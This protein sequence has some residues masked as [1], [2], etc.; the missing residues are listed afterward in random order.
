MKRIVVCMDG[1]W[2]T[3]RQDKPTNIALIARSVSHKETVRAPDGAER[4]IHQMLIYSHGVGSNVGAVARRGLSE[5]IANFNRIN[6]GAFGEGLED[7]I[8]DAYLRLC[9][10]YEEG[11]EIYIFGFSRG[12][13]AARRLAGLINTSGIL[14]RRH[15]DK[16]WDAYTL[17]HN[18]ARRDVTPEQL[19]EHDEAAA[20]FRKLYGKGGR[21]PDGTRTQSSEAPPIQFLGVFDTVV[22]RGLGHVL[23]SMTPWGRR[24]YRFRNKL[25]SEN[26]LAARHAVAVDERRLAF[27]ATLWEDLEESNAAARA[28]P[29]ADP[30][31]TYYQQ[32][33]F[34]GTHGD[35][36][37]GDGSKLSA[38]SLKWMTEGAAEMGLRFYDS[39]GDDRSPAAE[40]IEGSGLAYDAP[41]TRAPWWK[42]LVYPVHF[43]GRL[44]RIWTDRRNPPSSEHMDALFDPSV[45]RRASADHVRPRYTPGA[46]RPFRKL[47]KEWKKLNPLQ[48]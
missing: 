35:V 38:L 43:P 1:T 4:H 8:V 10:N 25:V 20:Q 14:S 24:R 36:G 45:L 26:V 34:V 5:F 23:A 2:Q 21:N 18:S 12:A 15:V 22:Q 7:G 6:G 27:P 42:A 3:L 13:F 33:W 39:Y 29:G 11:D 32:R 30:T 41:I 44:R 48:D 9:F 47:L 37:G 31:R 46:L 17:Y 28:R 19:A 40:L 16:A